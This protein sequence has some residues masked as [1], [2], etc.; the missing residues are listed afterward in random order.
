[1][2]NRN[3]ALPYPR[4]CLRRYIARLL[5]RALLPILFRIQIFGKANFP[6]HGP[7]IVVGNHTAI[8]EVVLMVIFPHGRLKS[9][10]VRMSHTNGLPKS[11]LVFMDTFGTSAG[12][13]TGML[14]G[15]LRQCSTRVVYWVS[16]RKGESGKQPKGGCSLA[17]PG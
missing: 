16:F 17:L 9:W 4:L 13:L 14:F 2:T 7:L 12:I 5:G 1:M 3:Q 6:A 10:A 11:R 8:M 15:K